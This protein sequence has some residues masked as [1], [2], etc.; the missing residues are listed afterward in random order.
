[1]SEFVKVSKSHLD[2]LRG[3]IERLVEFE[4]N[5]IDEKSVIFAEY[6][7]NPDD[8]PFDLSNPNILIYK[9]CPEW[10][11]EE[12]KAAY[13]NGLEYLSPI[14]EFNP[15]YCYLKSTCFSDGSI[16]RIPPNPKYEPFDISTCPYLAQVKY[17]NYDTVYTILGFSDGLVNLNENVKFGPKWLLEKC[18]VSYDKGKTWQPAGIEVK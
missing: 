5:H 12:Y 9:D 10:V 17:K 13:G 8:E 16:L 6:K 15:A 2:C 1:M 18:L 4:K 3:A 14:G 7:S 11:Q